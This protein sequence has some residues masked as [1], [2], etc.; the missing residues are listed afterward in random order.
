MTLI[1]DRIFP[2]HFRNYSI[3]AINSQGLARLHF[4]LARR[5]LL[6]TSVL[7]VTFILS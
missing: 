6:T 2:Q 5:T 4:Q 3:V 1:I 7:F